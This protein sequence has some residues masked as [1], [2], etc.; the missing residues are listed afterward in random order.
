MSKDKKDPSGEPNL[1]ASGVDMESTS[2]VSDAMEEARKSGDTVAYSTYKKALRD[3]KR[4]QDE[5]NSLIAQQ[6]RYEEEKLQAE[7]KKDEVISNLR[8]QLD[9]HKRQMELRDQQMAY[10]KVSSQ[11]MNAAAKRGCRD[12]QSLVR[13][14]DK[15]FPTLDLDS[16]F[17]VNDQ[18]LSMLLDRAEKDYTYFFQREAPKV[19]DGTP[20]GPPVNAGKTLK[21]LTMEEKL[22]L[23]AQKTRPGS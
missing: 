19:S 23:L 10:E 3:L 22:R 9:D 12:P 17:N 5:R 16:G 18:D 6:Q 1:N 2:S 4:I 8:K 14:L 11:V 13:L 7:G 15:D 20:A 21:D